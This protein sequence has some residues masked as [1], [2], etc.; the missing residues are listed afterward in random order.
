LKPTLPVQILADKSTKLFILAIAGKSH[1]VTW[2]KM[3]LF[4]VHRYFY[5]SLKK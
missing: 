4:R 2:V 1:T 5:F 3:D